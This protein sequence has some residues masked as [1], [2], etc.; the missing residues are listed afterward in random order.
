[1]KKDKIVEWPL[2]GSFPWCCAILAGALWLSSPVAKAQVIAYDGF[3]YGVPNG[4]SV[5]GLN[6]GT[7][8][9]TA[10]SPSGS[11]FITN[12]LSYA[13]INSS[14]EAMAYTA[15]ATLNN[16]GR[17]WGAAGNIPTGTYWY[18]LLINP[19]DTGGAGPYS[20]GTFF[21]S[22]SGAGNQDGFGFRYD[23]TGS[24][25]SLNLTADTVNGSAGTALNFAYD[26]T[27]FI[28]GQVIVGATSSSSQIWVF[29]NGN[30]P[31]SQAGL[32]TGSISSQAIGA[33]S[34]FSNIGGRAFGNSAN[35]VFD[36]ITIGNSF[37]DVVPVPEPATMALLTGGLMTAWVVR[38]KVRQ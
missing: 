1:M 24:G 13:G 8:W 10:Y 36:E 25:N 28:V 2:T 23:N 11:I 27:L 33:S 35:T 30:L 34:L 31:T 16:S 18:S 37:A 5:A 21:I 20:R 26:Q 29:N 7:G 6:G 12:G 22:G 19:S 9:Q 32:G 38:R 15:N 3:N 17:T 4:T 14:G